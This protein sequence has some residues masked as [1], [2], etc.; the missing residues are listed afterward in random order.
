MEN[1]IRVVGI[2][3]GNFASLGALASTMGGVMYT[4]SFREV[5][6]FLVQAWK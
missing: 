6:H 1:P 5:E 3:T 4:H 2:I